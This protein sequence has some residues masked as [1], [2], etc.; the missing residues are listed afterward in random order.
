[1]HLPISGPDQ[2]VAQGEAQD[3]LGQPREKNVQTR[4]IQRSKR[5]V[6]PLGR[7]R[8]VG[9]GPKRLDPLEQTCW[10]GS[11]VLGE[12]QEPDPVALGQ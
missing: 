2:P 7:E 10:K 12:G 6:K 11:Q 8:R 1:M 4:G 3:G 9:F 5:R